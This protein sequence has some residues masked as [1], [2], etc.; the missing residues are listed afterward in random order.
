M[1]PKLGSLA[2]EETL[3]GSVPQSYCLPSTV[4][5]DFYLSNYIV[6]Y[7]Q[8]K[9]K[10]TFGVGYFCCFISTYNFYV[11]HILLDRNETVAIATVAVAHLG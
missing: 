8:L 2:K 3:L 7:F 9:V 10:D 11:S 6:P 4:V 5:H 1:D